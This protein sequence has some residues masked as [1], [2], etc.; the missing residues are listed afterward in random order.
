MARLSA[1][2]VDKV[3][4]AA[5]ASAQPLDKAAMLSKLGS[6]VSSG[7]FHYRAL[8][9]ALNLNGGV[10]SLDTVFHGRKQ[11]VRLRAYVDLSQLAIDSEWQVM[12]NQTGAEPLPAITVG[13]AGPL[14]DLAELDRRLDAEEVFRALTVRKMT[15]DMEKLE[16][17]SGPRTGGWT[18]TQEQTPKPGGKQAPSQREAEDRAPVA[19]APNDSE[20]VPVKPQAFQEQIRSILSRHETPAKNVKSPESASQG[21]GNASGASA[22]NP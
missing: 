10:L 18:A 15:R 2:G 21:A 5:V 7:D 3:L 20:A 11:N 9:A 12:L 8:K 17:L 1:E 6:A 13:Y 16:R 4:N 19:P 14:A 22:A